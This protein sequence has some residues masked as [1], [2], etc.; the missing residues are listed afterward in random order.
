[1]ERFRRQVI[2][3]QI[4]EKGQRKL[5]EE[6]V[7]ILAEKIPNML[8]LY[9]AAVG[10]INITIYLKEISNIEGLVEHAKDLNPELKIQIKGLNDYRK[11]KDNNKT[12]IIVGGRNFIDEITEKLEEGPYIIA[13]AQPWEVYIKECSNFK[14]L[15]WILSK[16]T[17]FVETQDNFPLT[18]AFNFLGTILTTEVIKKVLGL[19]VSLEQGFSFNL[20]TSD[21]DMGLGENNIKFGNLNLRN[22]KVLVVGAGGLGSPVALT[23]GRI[24]IGTIGLVDYDQVEISNLNRQILHSTSKIGLFKVE[25]AQK[26]LSSLYP[27]VKVIPYKVK[28]TEENVREI[29]KDYDVVIGALDNIPSRYILNDG[30]YRENIP[31]IEGAIKTFYGQVTNIIP[32]VTP[33]YRCMV[34][35]REDYFVKREIGIVGSLPGTIGVLQCVEAIKNLVGIKS[36]LQGK[37]LMHDSLERDFIKIPFMINHKCP[38]CSS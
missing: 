26:L 3:P 10:I 12:T 22:R 15:Q 5:M 24:G 33:C 37:V 11:L 25:S 35:Q 4:G 2:I 29:I 38:L 34:P 21:A 31:Y 20:L 14:D 13:L 27:D 36:N 16:T 23:L 28:I 1:M 18:L 30:C 8:L 19:G 32:K 7:E 17:G 6:N 9:L